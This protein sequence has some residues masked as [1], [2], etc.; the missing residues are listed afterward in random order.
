MTYPDLHTSTY[1]ARQRRP[2]MARPDPDDKP[3]L[4]PADV[5]AIAARVAELVAERLATARP[6]ARRNAPPRATSSDETTLGA[7]GLRRRR[8]G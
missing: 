7:M 3:T 1:P 6:T 5:D 8:A 2:H 4:T